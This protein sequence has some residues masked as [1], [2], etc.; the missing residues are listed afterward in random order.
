MSNTDN[1]ATPPPAPPSTPP[2]PP[3]QVSF[4]RDEANY[5]LHVVDFHRELIVGITKDVAPL[6][7]PVVLAFLQ[8]AIETQIH[9]SR[10]AFDEQRVFFNTIYPVVLHQNA[11]EHPEES[12]EGS[13][14]I[15]VPTPR[16]GPALDTYSD[17]P[18]IITPSGSKLVN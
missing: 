18:R 17:P 13:I 8:S 2:A 5:F 3:A 4:S 16:N 6:D 7:L 10:Q 11:E 12:T 9:Q 1:L 15:V 14:M